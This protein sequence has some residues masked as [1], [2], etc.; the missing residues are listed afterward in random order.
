DASYREVLPNFQVRVTRE[1][2][3]TLR[4]LSP[5]E[6]RTNE[7]GEA[8]YRREVHSAL[9]D[10]PYLMFFNNGDPTLFNP[11]ANSV[12]AT[13]QQLS[14]R[15]QLDEP[16]S[17]ETHLSI[18]R[19]PVETVSRLLCDLAVP[20]ERLIGGRPHDLAVNPGGDYRSTTGDT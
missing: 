10:A 17:V 18:A 7:F 6:G 2:Y 16:T 4:E 15:G 13:V 14:I 1:T 19:R 11:I 8:C 12:L 9:H 3:A 20:G 5:P